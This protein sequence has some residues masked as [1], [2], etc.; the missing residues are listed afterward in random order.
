VIGLNSELLVGATIGWYV[1]GTTTPIN[2]F[3]TSALSIANQ[4]PVPADANGRFPAMWLAPGTYKYVLTPGGGETPVTLDG[5]VAPADTPDIDATL[6]DF[7]AGNAPLPI[8][9]GG[10]ASGS[11][12]DAIAAL[13]G[14]PLAGA[15]FTGP[16]GQGSKGPYLYLSAGG[17]V[18][19]IVF[20]TA[21]AASDPRTGNNQFWATYP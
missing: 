11:A 14:A 19:G 21:A 13:G 9:S 3:T 12:V 18:G 5:Y 7:L 20:V 4:N 2:S 15:T 6:D 10:T 8:A 17:L 16:I 1:G